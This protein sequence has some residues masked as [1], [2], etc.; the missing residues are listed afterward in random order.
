MTGN[1]RLFG[2]VVGGLSLEGTMSNAAFENDLGGGVV[3]SWISMI[4]VSVLMNF[5]PLLSYREC[6]I[7]KWI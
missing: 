7:V 3:E 5:L 6:E 4:S 1:V 2:G